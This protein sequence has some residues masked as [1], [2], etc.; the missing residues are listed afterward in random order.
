[1]KL[2]P[3]S[4]NCPKINL[5]FSSKYFITAVDL[6]TLTLKSLKHQLNLLPLLFCGMGGICSVALW[7]RHGETLQ[8]FSSLALEFGLLC[9]EPGS[10]LTCLLVTETFPS[11]LVARVADHH[12][13]AVA[14]RRIDVGLQ[15]AETKLAAVFQL[16]VRFMPQF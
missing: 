6:N 14:S 4:S 8:L 1:M 3:F 16:S 10:Q 2:V 7:N 11:L 12:R 15:V 5:S 9:V 13:H